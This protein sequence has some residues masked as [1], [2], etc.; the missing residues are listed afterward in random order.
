MFTS[1]AWMGC[2][3][4]ATATCQCIG[5]MSCIDIK[6]EASVVQVFPCLPEWSY[7]IT[8]A[9]AWEIIIPRH[10]E[11]TTTATEE[12]IADKN[13][14]KQTGQHTFTTHDHTHYAAHRMHSPCSLQYVAWQPGILTYVNIT[15]ILVELMF[16]L[17]CKIT[18]AEQNVS[19]HSRCDQ[20]SKINL[21]SQPCA[22]IRCCGGKQ[23]SQSL[24][25]VNPIPPQN[26]NTQLHPKVRASV[27]QTLAFISVHAI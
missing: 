19:N 14:L 2:L 13:V 23:A 11:A 12:M 4:V 26:S 17:W 15:L 27:C 6:T 8:Y 21:K 3:S 9:A 25:T 22:L 7:D 20:I 18:L 24:E 16:I 5:E 10:T 1:T